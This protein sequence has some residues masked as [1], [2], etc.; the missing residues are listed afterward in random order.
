LNSE[1]D[2]AQS[3]GSPFYP[4][5]DEVQFIMP[6][7]GDELLRS[8][9]ANSSK[10]AVEA[11]THKLQ[12]QLADALREAETAKQRVQELENRL[13]SALHEQNTDMAD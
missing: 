3:P 13:N 11:A 9:I 1:G 8:L 2:G 6:N 12:T 5:A 7:V 4:A 10:L